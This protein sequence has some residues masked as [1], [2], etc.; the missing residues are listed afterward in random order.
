MSKLN[1]DV[2]YLIIRELQND[3]IA[4][5][6]CLLVNKTWS[7]IVIP[8]LWKNPWK[9]LKDGNESLLLKVIISHLSEKSKKNLSTRFKYL[10]NSYERPLFD[11]ISFCKYLNIQEIERIINTVDKKSRIKIIKDEIYD[12]FI[13]ENT[14]F[15]HLYIPYQFDRPLHLIP[16]FDKCFSEISFLSCNANISDDVIPGL[17][18]IFKS[19]RKL[20]LFIGANSNKY[21]IIRFIRTSKNLM[22]VRILNEFY[23]ER[24]Y[25]KVLEQTLIIHADNI[26]YFKMTKQ[27]TTDFLSSFVNLKV[28]VLDDRCRHMN[29]NVLRD[30]SLPSLQILKASGIQL[31]ILANL[32]K[33][34]GGNL[35]EIKIN[36]FYPSD[37]DM[38]MIIRTIYQNCPNLKYLKL[39]IEY[40][41]FLHLENL[42]TN[43]VNLI[44]LFFIINNNSYLIEYYDWDSLFR[45]LAK[46]SPI[47]LFKFKFYIYKAPE[48]KSLKLFLDNWKGRH[49]MLLH[50]THYGENS[51]RDTIKSYSVLIEK[52]KSEGIIKKYVDNFSGLAFKDFEWIQNK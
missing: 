6:T 28:L 52:S 1:G 50:I 16:G 30:L 4:L 13:N 34:A 39:P 40:I 23:S 19:I 38:I 11:Y 33:N 42:L 15:T 35:I 26:L 20:E 43:C 14:R 48:L 2:L 27:L 45:I 41:S 8:I 7:E 12:L 5:R 31:G 18:E 37:G 47:N 3:E 36:K 51:N 29:W 10:L 24:T 9:Y 49:P 44:G 46:Y 22:S 21:E 32:I 25:C 17:T